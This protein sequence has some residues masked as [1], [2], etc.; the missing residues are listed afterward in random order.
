MR[1]T[2]THKDATSTAGWRT[3]SPD[4]VSERHNV[5]KRC[6]KKAF[7][8]VTPLQYTT[9]VSSRAGDPSNFELAYPIVA[10]KGPCAPDC[11][12]L[13]A[14]KSRAAQLGHQKLVTRAQRIAERAGC[15]WARKG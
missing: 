15:A 2:G 4:L 6:G 5:F 3:A 8:L 1:V 12:G 7:L 11:R 14:A 9:H 10:T 13:W